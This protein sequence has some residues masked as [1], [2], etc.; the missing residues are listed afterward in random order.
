M[1]TNGTLVTPERARRLKALDVQV[2]L[3]LDGCRAAHEATRPQRGGRSSFDDVVAG[4]HNLLAAGLG[5][6]VI[7]VVAPENVRWLGES[8]RFLAEL[9]AKEI[10]LNPAFECA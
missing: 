7:A 9:G 5:L 4:G 3:S 6:Q 8:V 10:I 1:T 2:T